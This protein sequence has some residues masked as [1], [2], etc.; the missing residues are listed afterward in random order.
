[1]KITH[2]KA[3]EIFDSRG[4]PLEVVLLLVVV[5][6]G[7]LRAARALLP[8]P[9]MPLLHLM[10]ELLQLKLLGVHQRLLAPRVGLLVER[11]LL[12]HGKL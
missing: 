8:C 9:Q 2:I 6:A 10:L 4:R 5:V 3:R 12:R 7:A 1:M 11:V